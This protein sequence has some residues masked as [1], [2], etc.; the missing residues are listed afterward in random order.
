ML[1]KADTSFNTGK[2]GGFRVSPAFHPTKAGDFAW[3][4]TS[5]LK[6]SPEEEKALERLEA[7]YQIVRDTTL[8]IAKGYSTGFLCWGDGGIGKSFQIMRALK[9]AGIP[10]HLL[11]TRLTGPGLCKALKGDPKGLFLVEDIEDIFIERICLS[12]LR[13]AFWGQED[14][15]GK[16]VRPIT[17]ATASDKFNFDFT[18]EGQI[19]ATMNS[20]PDDF[21][22][23]K[24][25]KHRI[26][27]LKLEGERD[28]LLALAHKLAL[29]GYKCDK[30]MV[31]AE[32]C[33]QMWQL[34]KEKLPDGRSPDLRMLTRAARKYLGVS[35]LKLKTTWQ[36]ML[37]SAIKEGAP[38]PGVETP[39]KALGKNEAIAAEL[40]RKY[41]DNFKA[42]LPE[43]RKAT[44]RGKTA[45]YDALERLD[46]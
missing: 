31:P 1:E 20:Q 37:L 40:R 39:A 27:I 45:Y 29:Q 28:E 22:E 21:A 30:G 26:D 18:F 41:G 36:D 25:L 12:L 13:S 42:I 19:I 3:L 11:N 17:Y 8:L 35:A 5:L 38:G 46:R 4:R 16:M 44:R 23:L 34:Y 6:L 14:E 43:W 10:Y 7:K 24:A 2:A 9:E 15:N 32:M 33:V